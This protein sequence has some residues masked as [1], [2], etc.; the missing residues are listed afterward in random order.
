MVDE[1]VTIRDVAQLQALDAPRMLRPPT[2]LIL[3]LPGLSAEE[4]QAAG[5]RL[6]RYANE[7]GCDLGSKCML[8]GFVV[9]LAWL[10]V[11][12][13]IL[14]TRFLYGLGWPVLAA[15]VAAI[16]GKM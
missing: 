2:G 14:S 4:A 5:E 7:C 13:G 8:G 9:A 10:G 16:T 1:L 3:D 6:A 12:G 11:E 15:F